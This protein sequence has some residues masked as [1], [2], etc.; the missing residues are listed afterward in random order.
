[1]I[2]KIFKIN[3]DHMDYL[4]YKLNSEHNP[5]LK[6]HYA[7][8]KYTVYFSSRIYFN[9]LTNNFSSIFTNILEDEWVS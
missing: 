8:V 4:P 6:C 7:I 3:F 5:L 1:M 9:G 2:Q